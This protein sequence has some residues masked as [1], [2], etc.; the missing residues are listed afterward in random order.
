MLR[1]AHL[2]I[3]SAALLSAAV[4]AATYQFDPAH[5]FPLF[6]IDHLGFSTQ[7]G[8]FDASRG[9]LEYDSVQRTGSLEVVIDAASLDTG[10]PERDAILRGPDWFDVKRYPAITFRGQ[11]FVF[12][13]DQPVAVEGELTM[14]GVTRPLR[15]EILRLKCGLNLAAKKRECGADASA[16]LKRSEFG[17]RTGLPFV[18]DEVRLRIQAE[19]YL[20]SP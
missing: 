3:L 17:M 9:T 5:T 8:W 6:E 10:N 12:G 13:P 14:L 15:L 7:R 1:F 18:G 16:T 20:Q 19:A 11:R 4:Q 2:A